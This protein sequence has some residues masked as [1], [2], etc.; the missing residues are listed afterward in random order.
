MDSGNYYSYQDSNHLYYEKLFTIISQLRSI[1]SEAIMLPNSDQ[2]II[3]VETSIEVVESAITG[4]LYKNKTSIL[5]S[6]QI[7]LF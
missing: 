3:G 4:N 5:N 1:C 6:N 7:P 2:F